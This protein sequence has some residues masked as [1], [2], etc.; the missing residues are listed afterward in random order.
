MRR[1]LFPALLACAGAFNL[2]TL[3]TPG[4]PAS[5][6]VVIY[7]IPAL[8]RTARGTLI[9]VAEARTS[10]S[11]CS[12]KFLAFRR[13]TDNGTTWSPTAEIY[14]R[15][16][17]HDQGAGN[18][19]IV[20]DAV[21]ST[22]VL[23][24][25]VNA[26]GFC[27]PNL[28]SFHIDDGGSD[29]AAWSAPRN[30][31][32]SLGAFAGATPGPGTGA[33]V[34]AGAPHAG[35]LVIPA[36]WGAYRDVVSWFSDDHGATWTL[37]STPLPGLDEVVVAA[38][39]SGELL[40]N[41]RT[42]HL[43]ASCDCRAVTTSSDGGA[44]WA[45]PV[46]F[47]AA[48]IEPVCQGSMV[49][50]GPLRDAPAGA[51]YFANP[52]SRTARVDLTVRRSDDGGRSWPHSLLIEPS[53]TLGYSCLAAGAPIAGA[54]G[55]ELGAILFE[56]PGGTIA[57]TLFPTVLPPTPP[58]P[59]PPAVIPATAA[60]WTGRFSPAAD[61]SVRFDFPGVTA[62]FR[63]ANAT[64]FSAVFTGT[65]GA[66]PDG[67]RLESAVDGAVLDTHA[68]GSFWVLGATPAAP[69]EI[70]VASALDPSVPHTLTIRFAD[71]A[72]WAGCSA[73]ETLALLGV[74][75]DGAALPP[76][77][78]SE[79]SL[80]FVGDSITAGFGTAP[81]CTGA[82]SSTGGREDSSRSAALAAICPALGA[83]CS[84]VAI[85]GDTVIVPDGGAPAAKPPMPLV[86]NRSLTY[87]SGSD[88]AWDFKARPPPRGVLLNLGTNDVA[89]N[90]SFRET[91]E[92]ALADFVVAISSATGA[93][94]GAP[95]PPPRA[96]LWC[97]PISNEYCAP[98]SAA[99]QAAV[100]RGA[101]AAFLGFVNASL[102][103]CDGHPGEAGQQ[104]LGAALLP[105]IR[106]QLGW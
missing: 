76:S 101:D 44:T 69:Y 26:P 42:D 70:T 32:G 60:K 38:L 2:T 4:E 18:P 61:G 99:V 33:Q 5:W 65:C 58:P 82:H 35:R 72:R 102:D 62:A 105:L 73:A 53:A 7:R 13:S 106:A 96:L 84:L 47:D 77:A 97:G 3:F 16:L 104:I 67:A 50:I 88:T 14:G 8:V 31:S 100:A 40:L 48:L 41:A 57:F 93:Y 6:G 46:R 56:A 29:G 66:A 87:A 45:L 15:A 12:Y 92:A 17:T 28:W 25:S 19:A 55:A 95:G 85:S 103:G 36:H 34:P 64:F 89:S 30:I 23:H 71:E 39:P 86:Y 90:A 63:V 75:T 49:L 24:G 54:D 52:A 37:T 9:A 27:N 74:R 81:P 98:M 68:R 83:D 79:R 94:A 10:N 51:L 59:P 20:F 22:I 1:L 91:Y 80:E 43:N 21:T 11:D 78:P